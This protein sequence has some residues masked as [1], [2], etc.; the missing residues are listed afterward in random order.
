MTAPAAAA[1][2][3]AAATPTRWGDREGRRRDILAAARRQLTDGGYL[4]LNMRDIARGAGVSPGTLYA[5]FATKDEI[6][7]TLY[8]EAIEA[9]NR[10]IGPMCKT[11]ADLT[12]LLTDL[13]TAYLDLYGTYGRSFTVWSVLHDEGAPGEHDLPAEL[14]GRLRRAALAQGDLVLLGVRTAA[15]AE[16]RT[17]VDEPYIVSFVWMAFSG[18]A[19]N[20]TGERRHLSRRTRTELIGHAARTIA[21][22]ITA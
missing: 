14:L 13:A 2:D 11:A 5:Y 22:G 19:E 15:A 12:G 21:A 6:F 18:I 1:A 3:P 20:L 4:G 7:A 10:R 16:G 8:A 9:H 17:L